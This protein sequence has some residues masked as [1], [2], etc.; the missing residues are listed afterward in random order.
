[1]KSTMTNFLADLS[2][3]LFPSYCEVCG[4][5]IDGYDTYVCSHCLDALP[6][7]HDAELIY[8]AW[9][10]L[11]GHVPFTEYQSDFVFTHG[12]PTRRLIHHIKYHNA[13]HLGYRMAHHFADYHRRSYHFADITMVLPIPL[14]AQRLRQRSYNQ[15]EYIAHGIADPLGLEV[16]PRI[17]TRGTS[18]GS[19]TYRSRDAR[20][21]A[22]VNVFAVSQP[23]LV[24]GRRILIVDDVLTSG[25]TLIHAARAVLAAGAESVSFYTLAL[26]VYI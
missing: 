2:A 5:R 21:Q 4:Q 12:N 19:Q 17:L 7:Y 24:A 15:A 18:H 6:H 26:N 3:Y 16:C 13:P 10:R 20:W 22:M 8:H 11:A 9:D 14:T 23:S 1:M 25:A